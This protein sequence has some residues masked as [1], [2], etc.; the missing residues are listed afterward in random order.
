LGVGRLHGQQHPWKGEGLGSGARLCS[1]GGS[2]GGERGVVLVRSAASEV[3]GRRERAVLNIWLAWAASGG[4]D[5]SKLALQLG[6]ADGGV[7]RRGWYGGRLG[8]RRGS[9]WPR[10]VGKEEGVGG[11]CEPRGI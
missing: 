2:T 11:P 5:E 4:G 7:E 8:W 6:L 9:R 3:V 10:V 1:G